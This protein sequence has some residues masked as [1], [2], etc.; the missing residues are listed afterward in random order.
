MPNRTDPGFNFG[1]SSRPSERIKLQKRLE[2]EERQANERQRDA[3]RARAQAVRMN[4]VSEFKESE[5]Q[6][7][8]FMINWWNIFVDSL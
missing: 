8:G 6:D 7:D 3:N 5:W 1:V 4:M 2:V